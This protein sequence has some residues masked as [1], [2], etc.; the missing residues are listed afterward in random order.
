MNKKKSAT[1]DIVNP[2]YGRFDDMVDVI[3]G[4]S[5]HVDD[6]AI[7]IA[8]ATETWSAPLQGVVPKKTKESGRARRV[9]FGAND[10]DE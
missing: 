9:S 3:I 8:S 1:L 4:K 5:G 2:P 7:S 6:A 10:N